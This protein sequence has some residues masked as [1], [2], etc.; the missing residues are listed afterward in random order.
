[1]DF[2]K[3]TDLHGVNWDLPSEDPLTLPFLRS[4]AASAS[5]TRFYIGAPAWGHRS[6]IGKIYSPGTKATE[7]LKA[8]AQSFNC[9]ELN[10]SHYRIPSSDQVV[11]WREQVSADFKFCPKVVQ[12]I[13]HSENGLLDKRTLA[14]WLQFLSSMGEN[15]GPSFLQLPPYFEYSK[16][17]QLFEFLQSWPTEYKLTLELRNPSW[18]REGHLLPAL[19]EYLQKRGIGAVITDTAGR[20]DVLHSS[21]SASYTFIRF[22]GNML[23][24]SDQRRI[25][26]WTK[27]LLAWKEAGIQE[28]YFIV[29]QPD[30][31]LAP[32]TAKLVLEDWSARGLATL[33]PLKFH[34]PQELSFAID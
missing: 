12:T 32:E 15:L 19:N 27:R 31:E 1:M 23:D 21:V 16:K 13:S 25:E 4:L 28:I 22:V 29:H 7:F 34:E 18:F 30:D 9:I 17:A 6:W 11:K 2:G 26:D 24:S 14:E 10:T 8:Y 5:E 20:R 3:L 33:P